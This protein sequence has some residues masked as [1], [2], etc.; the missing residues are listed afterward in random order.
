MEN[1]RCLLLF[2]SRP[3]NRA[4]A[5][6]LA[7]P[8]PRNR[9][10]IASPEGVN[11]ATMRRGGRQTRRLLARAQPCSTRARAANTR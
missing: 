7:P 3:R 11:R 8:P 4:H 10:R 5:T 6:F 2:A 1:R 9:A